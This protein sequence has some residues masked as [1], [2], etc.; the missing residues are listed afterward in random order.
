MCSEELPQMELGWEDGARRINECEYLYIDSVR[1][2]EELTLDLIVTE[3]KVQARILVP[4]DQSPVEQLRLGATPIESCSPRYR[5]ILQN[6]MAIRTSATPAILKA[7]LMGRET[8]ES[9]RGGG[10]FI[11]HGSDEPEQP[12]GNRC[13]TGWI[14]RHQQAHVEQRAGKQKYGSYV[15]QD[16][17]AIVSPPG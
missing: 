1:E 13:D 4:R 7:L 5:G 16:H 8:S 10:L 9:S 15:V 17:G 6:R 14:D 3:T 12:L 11:P 2:L